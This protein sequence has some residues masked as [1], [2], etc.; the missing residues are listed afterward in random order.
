[1]NAVHSLNSAAIIEPVLWETHSR[2]G[3]G[4][5]PTRVD[6]SAACHL[7]RSCNRSILDKTGTPTGNA[8]SGTAE[9]LNTSGKLG[10]RFCCIFHPH[11]FVPESLDGDQYKALTQYKER[12][13]QQGLYFK[14]E[15]LAEFRELL[16]APSC[17]SDD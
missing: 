3:M 6:Q 10:S 7:L 2:P 14:Y 15:T 12:L 17:R 11:L 5:R 4:N 9:E 1:M 16:P 13:G 8:E